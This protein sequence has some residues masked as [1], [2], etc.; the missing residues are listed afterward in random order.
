MNGNINCS[1]GS[2]E[3]LRSLGG[4]G[5]PQVRRSQVVLSHS[6][7]LF[8]GRSEVQMWSGL[9]IQASK[10]ADRKSVKSGRKADNMM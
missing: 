1:K 8:I 5:C 3:E 4:L 2:G 7:Q 6:D 9:G 10:Q